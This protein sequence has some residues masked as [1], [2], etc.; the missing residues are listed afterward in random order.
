MADIL[1]KLHGL[2]LD[3]D[4]SP[5]LAEV[6]LEISSGVTAVV[7]YSG[8]GKSSLLNVLAGMESPDAGRV[9]CCVGEPLAA[10]FDLPL[11]WAPQDSGLWPH[12][13]VRDHIMI[14]CSANGGKLGDSAVSV[15]NRL[16]AFDLTHRQ[17]A[18][19]GELSRGEQSRLAI[20]RALS[21]NPA[22]L[23][24]DEPLAHVDPVR[25]PEYWSNIS[26]H[27]KTTGASLV[28]STHEP[29]AAIR[30]SQSVICLDAG[31]VKY[32]GSTR[33]LYDSPPSEE[34]ARFLGPINW[35]Q[36]EDRSVWLGQQAVDEELGV[37]PENIQLTTIEDGPLEILS[38]RFCGSYAETTLKHIA[39]SLTKTIL[40][41]PAGSAHHAGQTVSLEVHS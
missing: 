11:F 12:M 27:L 41:R 7:G 22:V 33:Q 17:H 19:P 16:A 2:T 24:M 20:A 35:F 39:T 15:D 32:F 18:F 23:L 4:R 21:A 26:E 38:F 30:E 13:S 25:T 40:H 10:G 6:S 36:A 1:W 29:S 8:A 14:V 37:R 9:E 5:R 3:G 28:F 34:V 31:R